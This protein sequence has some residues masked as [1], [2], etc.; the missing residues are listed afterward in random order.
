MFNFTALLPVQVSQGLLYSLGAPLLSYALPSLYDVR[1]CPAQN[2]NNTADCPRQG[3]TSITLTGRDFG[4]NLPKVIVGSLPCGNVR[5]VPTPG[6]EH[7]QVIC[8]LQPG[9]LTAEAVLVIQVTRK[10]ES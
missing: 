10:E 8:D 5:N 1:G 2:L 7:F 9:V 3:G 6:L 4:R